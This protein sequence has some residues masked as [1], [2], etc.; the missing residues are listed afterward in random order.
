MP[1]PVNQAEVSTTKSRTA[2]LKPWQF[3]PGQTGNPDGGPKGPKLGQLLRM[4]LRERPDEA[5]EI[6]QTLLQDALDGVA[7]ARKIVFD[8][9]D[10]PLVLKIEGL[11]EAEIHDK[12]RAMLGAL[13]DR[14]P[15]EF[16]ATLADVA[17]EQLGDA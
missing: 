1:E 3:K 5:E 8:R 14:L 7:D 4:R 6:I 9:H 17:R 12:L 15:A 16:H 11:S 2:H 13:R 10:G